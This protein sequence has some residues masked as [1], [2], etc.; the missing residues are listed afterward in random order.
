[1]RM[2][3]ALDAFGILWHPFAMRS[4]LGKSRSQF[5]ADMVADSCRKSPKKGMIW[6]EWDGHRWAGNV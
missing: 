3:E 5:V 6:C 1:M 2:F 4:W